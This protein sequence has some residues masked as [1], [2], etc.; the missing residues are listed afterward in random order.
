MERLS[1]F[2]KFI[3]F[4][5]NMGHP[6]CF[7]CPFLVYNLFIYLLFFFFG[8]MCNVVFSSVLHIQRQLCEHVSLPCLINLINN[9]FCIYIFVSVALSCGWFQLISFFFGFVWWCIAE[10]Q[11]FFICYLYP[12]SSRGN[13]FS[14]TFF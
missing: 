12:I 4:W 10:K 1:Y 6:C 14:T 7:C 8:I 5:R 2:K 13:L 11:F 9:L 3:H